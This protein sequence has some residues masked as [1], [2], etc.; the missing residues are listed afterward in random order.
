MDKIRSAAQPSGK[1]D[2][3]T[4]TVHRFFGERETIAEL[5][6]AYIIEQT[7]DRLAFGETPPVCQPID[8]VSGRK[9]VHR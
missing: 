1:Q 6:L 9:E 7:D 3:T 4:I 5:I 2:C 8:A